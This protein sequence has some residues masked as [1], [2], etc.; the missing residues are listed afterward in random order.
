MQRWGPEESFGGFPF[1]GGQPFEVLI[2]LDFDHMKIAINGSHFTE[3]RYRIPMNRISHLAID[4]DV[5]ISSINFEGSTQPSYSAPTA[6][7]VAVLPPYS[8]SGAAPYQAMPGAFVPPPAP[9]YATGAPYPPQASYA[10]PTY[11]T[12]GYP[13]PPYPGG[14]YPNQG[15]PT[16]AYPVRY[17]HYNNEGINN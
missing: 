11:P 9:A 16:T 4:G 14:N 1:A 6:P 10:G 8:T 12:G 15:Y 13:Q 17:E 3:F 5:S 2:L 7:P